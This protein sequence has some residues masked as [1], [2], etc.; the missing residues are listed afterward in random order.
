MMHVTIDLHTTFKGRD[1]CPHT[2][3]TCDVTIMELNAK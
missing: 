3:P 2:E 1:P